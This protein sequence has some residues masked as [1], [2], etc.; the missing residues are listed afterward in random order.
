MGRIVTLEMLDASLPRS[1]SVTTGSQ[2][3]S[4]SRVGKT[5]RKNITVT[6]LTAGVTVYI[7]KGDDTTLAVSGIGIALTANQAL[8]ET[9]Q[10]GSPCFQGAYVIIASGAGTVAVSED[11]ES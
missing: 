6:P 11:F 9:D 3:L 5:R 7:A 2:V 1:F 4:Y 10:S 8:V